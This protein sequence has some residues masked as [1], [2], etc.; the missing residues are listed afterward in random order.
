[1]RQH[2]FGKPIDVHHLDERGSRR[3]ADMKLPGA[4]SVVYDGRRYHTWDDVVRLLVDRCERAEHM[5]NLKGAEAD[6]S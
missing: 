5:V 4:G 1:M 2:G 6:A 3:E